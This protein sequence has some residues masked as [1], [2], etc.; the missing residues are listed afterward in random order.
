LS[1][2]AATADGG[3]YAVGQASYYSASNPLISA[4][5]AEL[6]PLG[7]SDGYIRKF[8]S[9]GTEE[10]TRLYGGSTADNVTSVTVDADGSAYVTG[11][12]Y[13]G[14]YY[15]K[16][17]TKFTSA[18]IQEWTFGKDVLPRGTSKAS[19]ALAPDD[20]STL[21]LGG[22]YYA[23]NGDSTFLT[24]VTLDESAPPDTLSTVYLTQRTTQAIAAAGN[25]VVYLTGYT[26]QSIEGQSYA[27][28]GDA[29]EKA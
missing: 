27:G 25:G 2:I 10:W 5:G 20:E 15:E 17:I 29:W 3:F 28:D 13:D 11:S 19:L 26:G 8:A 4:D 12:Y 14:G 16:Y 24:K 1:S 21:I 18:G 6:Q 9:D 22:S 23:G 7:D